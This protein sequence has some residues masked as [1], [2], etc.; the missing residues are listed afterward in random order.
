MVKVICQFVT[1]N[2]S[3]FSAGYA[4]LV[5]NIPDIQVLA[6]MCKIISKFLCFLSVGTCFFC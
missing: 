3:I 6:G 5:K 2:S 1:D 4:Y